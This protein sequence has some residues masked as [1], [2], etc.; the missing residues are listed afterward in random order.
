[1]CEDNILTF[2]KRDVGV[3]SHTIAKYQSPH[4]NPDCC[5]DLEDYFSYYEEPEPDTEDYELKYM[6]HPKEKY[7]D[8]E[9]YINYDY[10]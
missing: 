6:P 7:A 4:N 3:D 9:Q 5:E 1:M 10:S 2:Q 8:P